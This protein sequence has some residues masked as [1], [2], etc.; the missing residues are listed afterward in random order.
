MRHALLLLAGL[1][2]ACAARPATPAELPSRFEQPDAARAQALAPD[3]HARAERARVDAERARDGASARD[4]AERAEL[5]LEA[6]VAEA[7]RIELD[8]ARAAQEARHAQ[9]DGER[10]ALERARVAAVHA[11]R[12]EEAARV[13]RAEAARVFLQAE[14]DELRR[15]DRGER[16]RAQAQ[17]AAFYLK[18]AELVLAAAAAM[19]ADEAQRKP[20][21]AAIDAAARQKAG[22]AR[23]AAADRALARAQRLLGAARRA[24]GKPDRAELDSLLEGG[25]ERGLSIEPLPRGV[26]I[27]LEGFFRKGSAQLSPAGSRALRH[28]EALLRAHP[29]GPVQL[30]LLAGESAPASRRRLGKARA[31]RLKKALT[32]VAGPRL[33]AVAGA[34]A[35]PP[36]MVWVAY[37]PAP[38]G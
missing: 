31:E 8:R 7:D 11:I 10:A 17:A 32:E 35:G 23:A 38:G 6:A 12:R 2:S 21:R 9:V 18:R 22:S 4:H 15:R 28:L 37:T 16:E 20:V 25:R 33:Q 13:A 29:H 24:S 19:G 1:L 36:Q 14:E 3:L 30:E 34:G 5:L 27:S 26:A